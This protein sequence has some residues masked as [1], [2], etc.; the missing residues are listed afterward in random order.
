VVETLRKKKKKE[1]KSG[2][3]PDTKAEADKS[4]KTAAALGPAPDLTSGTRFAYLAT[5]YAPVTYSIEQA[6]DMQREYAHPTVYNL[7]KARVRL[8]L[9]LNMTLEKK[10][11][12]TIV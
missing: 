3:Q 1:S 12:S 2:V 8:R 10:V 11:R 5:D 6:L 4:K 9:E 7:P